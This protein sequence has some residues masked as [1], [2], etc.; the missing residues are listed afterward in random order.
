MGETPLH[1][2]A[3]KEFSSET[4]HYLLKAGADIEAKSHEKGKYNWTPLFY[5][6]E[7]KNNHLTFKHLLDQGANIHHKTGENWTPLHA[8]C[9]KGDSV[10]VR[11]FMKRGSN[12]RS[13]THVR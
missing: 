1:R 3:S 10:L 7:P 4:V 2:A 6:F 12:P 11:Q 9:L 5:A 13:L 8:A